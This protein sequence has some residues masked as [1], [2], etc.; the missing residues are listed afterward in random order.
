[1]GNSAAIELQ[2][3]L[4]CPACGTEKTETMPARRYRKLR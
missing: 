2:S 3:T 4:R 1:M